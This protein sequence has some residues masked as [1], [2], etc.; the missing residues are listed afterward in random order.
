MLLPRTVSVAWPPDLCTSGEIGRKVSRL[1]ALLLC[2]SAAMWQLGTPVCAHA[3][4][5]SHRHWLHGRTGCLHICGIQRHHV[6]DQAHCGLEL[7]AMALL[8]C[9]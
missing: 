1:S 3:I 8:A 9:L 6:V 5:Q 2:P 7:H 4:S